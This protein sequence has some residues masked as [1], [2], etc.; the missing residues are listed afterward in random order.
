MAV[1]NNSYPLDAKRRKVFTERCSNI[2]SHFLL[3][4]HFP[5]TAIF[6]TCESQIKLIYSYQGFAKFEPFNSLSIKTLLLWSDPKTS[7]CIRFQRKFK[8]NIILTIKESKSFVNY[9]PWWVMTSQNTYSEPFLRSGLASRCRLH[10]IN[11]I[12]SYGQHIEMVS[13]Q[14]NQC[15]I[16]FFLFLYKCHIICQ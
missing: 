9:L 13:S 3:S 4:D 10:S 12:L 6:W 11:H 1:R 8:K 5:P 2:F 15:G 16:I 7:K 14:L